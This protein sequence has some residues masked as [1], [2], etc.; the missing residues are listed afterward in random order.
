[1]A[2]FSSQVDSKTKIDEKV[3][4]SN[5]PCLLPYEDIHREATSLVFGHSFNYLQTLVSC[6]ECF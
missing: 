1:M 2:G 6:F 4:Y 3:D 5:L